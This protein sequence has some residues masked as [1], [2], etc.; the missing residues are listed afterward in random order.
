MVG[1]KNDLLVHQRL[2]KQRSQAQGLR[3]GQLGLVPGIYSTPELFDV[4]RG[5][6]PCLATEGHLNLG[7][8]D[9]RKRLTC[10]CL[11]EV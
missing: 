2:G 11:E 10:A 7:F 1:V 6:S 5:L 3:R 4:Y 8:C 9:E